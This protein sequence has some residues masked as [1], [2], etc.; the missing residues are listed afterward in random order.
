MGRGGEGGGGAGGREA[1][2]GLADLARGGQEVRKP[3]L[4]GD[5]ARALCS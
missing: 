5:P 3:V 1:G 2:A 4:A